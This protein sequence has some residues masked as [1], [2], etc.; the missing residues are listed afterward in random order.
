MEYLLPLFHSPGIVCC[1]LLL[2]QHITSPSYST[3]HPQP[4]T[5]DQSDMTVTGATTAR[6]ASVTYVPPFQFVSTNPAAVQVTGSVTSR[7]SFQ[8]AAEDRCDQRK[9]FMRSFLMLRLIQPSRL[10]Q[11]MLITRG[12]ICRPT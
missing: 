8:V 10:E 1:V 3:Q 11:A 7:S 4:H 5:H 2:E 12:H 6:I 9:R